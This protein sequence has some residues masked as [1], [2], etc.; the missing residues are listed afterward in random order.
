M[1]NNPLVVGFFPSILAA[2][3][4][5]FGIFITGLGHSLATNKI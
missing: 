4:F 3:A 5:N 1:G 2:V